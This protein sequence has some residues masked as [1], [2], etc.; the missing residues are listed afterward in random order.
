MCKDRYRIDGRN[1][2]LTPYD[3]EAFFAQRDAEDP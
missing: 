3:G 2:S 1:P